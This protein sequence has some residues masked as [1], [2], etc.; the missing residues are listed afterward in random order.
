MDRE[1]YYDILA[2]ADTGSKES[3]EEW[4]GYVANGILSEINK[5]FRLLDRD[6]A[7]KNLIIPAIKESRKDEPLS[8]KEYQRYIIDELVNNNDYIETKA[9]ERNAHDLLYLKAGVTKVRIYFWIE[10]QDV[11]CINWASY[12]GGVTVDIGLVKGSEIGSKG[13]AQA[14]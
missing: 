14:D 3:I 10:G 7:V 11:D 13:E 4:C 2:K 9:G 6:F 1:K 5:M 8:E 12:G